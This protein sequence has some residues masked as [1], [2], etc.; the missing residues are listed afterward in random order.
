VTASL[1]DRAVNV[2]VRGK[3]MGNGGGRKA[4]PVSRKGQQ[5]RVK[6]CQTARYVH[7]QRSRFFEA[8][9]GYLAELDK[10]LT[11]LE[12]GLDQK[13]EKSG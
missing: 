1:A 11:V 7:G 9:Q 6:H 13:R 10:A 12:A 5:N 8:V 2:V 4:P 3:A